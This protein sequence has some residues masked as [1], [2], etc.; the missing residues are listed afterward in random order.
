MRYFLD[1]AF[2]G[3]DFS[4]WQSQP[5]APTVQETL[6]KALIAALGDAGGLTGA[7]RTDAGVHARQM[8]A[9]FDGPDGLHLE[10]LRFL[11]RI[12]SELPSSIRIRSIRPVKP[13]AH[14]RFDALKRTYHYVVDRERSPFLTGLAMD[15]YGPLDFS[16]METAA[17]MIIGKLDFECFARSGSDVNNHICD[18]SISRWI[19]GPGILTY[20]IT[21]NRFLR[22]MVRAIV[23]TMIDIGRGRFSLEDFQRILDSGSRSMAGTSAP[24]HGLYLW[25][26]SY[27][28]DVFLEDEGAAGAS[29]D[30]SVSSPGRNI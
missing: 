28:P 21:A 17:A 3:K 11:Q 29:T 4:G 9:H 12:Q 14:A 30:L 20:E 1:I 26:V 25:E 10:N 18:V 24:A 13:S 2:N 23:G 8:I 22:N 7:G 16:A 15:Y 6:G 5:C 19:Q 27:P